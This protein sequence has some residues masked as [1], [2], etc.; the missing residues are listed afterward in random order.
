[1]PP[2]VSGGVTYDPVLAQMAATPQERREEYRAYV[3]SGLARDD[4]EM[5]KALCASAR[6]IGGLKFREWVEAKHEKL[7]EQLGSRE[8]VAFRRVRGALPVEEVLQTVATFA[9][10]KREALLCRQ[11]GMLAR[12][13]A[14]RWLCRYSDL[15]QRQAAKTLGLTTGSAV[16][17]QLQALARKLAADEALRERINRAEDRLERRTRKGN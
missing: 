1:M 12:G 8:D 9:G 14:A 16:S 5:R 11:R 15:T 7:C 10:V 6:S 3:E 13:L 4:E 2:C 17:A